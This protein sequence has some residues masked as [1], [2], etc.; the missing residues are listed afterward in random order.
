MYI[1]RKPTQTLLWEGGE[2]NGEGID[3][4]DWYWIFFNILFDKIAYW[5]Q[6]KTQ[7]RCAFLSMLT[8][9]CSLPLSADV[10]AQKWIN[11]PCLKEAA[12]FWFRS[13][14]L[15]TRD[16]EIVTFLS[17]ASPLGFVTLPEVVLIQTQGPCPDCSSLQISRGKSSP[18]RRQSPRL[19]PEKVKVI[20]KAWGRRTPWQQWFGNS[21]VSCAWPA[22]SFDQCINSWCFCPSFFQVT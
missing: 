1:S 4:L 9:W 7:V 6:A 8:Q 20:S 13:N 14:C 22:L 18:M 16:C 5:G 3:L 15:H 12:G 2:L 21:E 11:E 19:G 10:W 17:P